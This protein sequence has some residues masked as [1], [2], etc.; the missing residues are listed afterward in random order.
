MRDV[1]KHVHETLEKACEKKKNLEKKK[2]AA[3][4]STTPPGEPDASGN[5]STRAGDDEMPD[6]LD[7]TRTKDDSLGNSP[8]DSSKRKRDDETP[9]STPM[10]DEN[11]SSFK[12]LKSTDVDTPPP[13][14]PPPPPAGN[15]RF[16]EQG[17]AIDNDEL[18]AFQQAALD[19]F[20]NGVTETTNFAADDARSKNEIS[21]H[22]NKAVKADLGDISGTNGHPSPTQLATPST[23]D[24]YNFEG[25]NPERLRHLGLANGR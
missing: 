5:T 17:D 19:S 16:D 24:S 10:E 9:N 3:G 13:P 25:V 21:M 8:D 2:S 11:G 20:E 12:R 18:D 4:G 6:A 22:V 1:K 23:S 15:T 7:G 14:P